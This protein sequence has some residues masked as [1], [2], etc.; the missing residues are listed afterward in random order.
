MGNRGNIT[1]GSMG[2]MGLDILPGG[3]GYPGKYDSPPTIQSQVVVDID[4]LINKPTSK[5][6]DY[7]YTLINNNGNKL[8][9]KIYIYIYIFL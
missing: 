4:A 5:E 1:G 8:G 7:I 2:I 6:V 9:M 3:K